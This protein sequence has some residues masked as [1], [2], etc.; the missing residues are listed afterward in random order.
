MNENYDVKGSVHRLEQR[1]PWKYGLDDLPNRES[2][3]VEFSPSG[4]VLQQTDYTNA[5]GIYRSSRFLYGESGG[6]IRTLEFDGTGNKLTVS[7]FEYPG[8]RRTRITRDA[9]GIETGRDVEEFDGNLLI[10][11]RHVPRKRATHPIEIV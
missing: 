8:G 11:N 9:V 10:A 4:Q 1:R 6:L 3:D 2:F 5:G 7:E